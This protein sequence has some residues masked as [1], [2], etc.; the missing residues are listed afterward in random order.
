MN[1]TY[2]KLQ[3]LE[4]LWY[5][6]VHDGDWVTEKEIDLPDTDIEHKTVGYFLMETDKTIAVVQSYGVAPDKDAGY[7]VD[8]IMRIPKVAIKLV[9]R[10]N[11]ES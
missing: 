7:H 3:L 5:D 6:A 10:I 1:Q 9:R 8:C 11:E 4:I 2:P